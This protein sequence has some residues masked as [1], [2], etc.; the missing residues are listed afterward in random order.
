MDERQPGRARSG[1]TRLAQAV[2]HTIKVLRTDQRVSRRDLARQVDISYSYLTEIENG[3]KPG[4]NTILGPIAEALGI[5][6]HELIAAAE[7]RMLES[8]ARPS[9][10]ELRGAAEM[11]EPAPSPRRGVASPSVRRARLT[12]QRSPEFDQL[13]ILRT[14]R[15]NASSNDEVLAELE[16]LI[17]LLPPEDQQRVLDMARRLLG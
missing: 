2:G 9:R 13:N 5:Q 16:E 11:I 6:L 1:D 10:M 7:A 14:Q 8:E 15:A 17:P 3:T 4:S 12:S